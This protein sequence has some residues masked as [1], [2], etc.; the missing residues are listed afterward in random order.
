MSLQETRTFLMSETWMCN[1]VAWGK[2]C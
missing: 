1:A 2:H